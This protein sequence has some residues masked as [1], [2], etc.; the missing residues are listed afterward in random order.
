MSSIWK[1]QKIKRADVI[2]IFLIVAIV[3]AGMLI[4]Y[5]YGDYKKNVNLNGTSASLNEEIKE[6]LTC[7]IEIRCDAI[8]DHMEQL[9]PQ[10]GDYVPANGIVLEKAT[11]HFS[12]GE[13]VFEVLERVCKDAGLQLE[14]SWTPLYDNYYIEGINHI[15]EFDCGSESGWMYQVNGEFPNYGCS[16]FTIKPGDEIVWCYTCEGMGTDV[17]AEGY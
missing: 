15:Y 17:G 4:V 8:L 12:E 1:K 16:S 14:Y 3:I 5:K 7:S 11:I 13:T 6:G 9:V 2:M 10:K